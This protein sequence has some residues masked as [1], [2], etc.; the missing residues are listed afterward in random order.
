[1]DMMMATFICGK[2]NG[3]YNTLPD[4]KIYIDTLKGL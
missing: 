1:M 3:K 2:F 4:K